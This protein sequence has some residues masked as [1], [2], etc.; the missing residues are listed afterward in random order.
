MTARVSIQ[1]DSIQHIQIATGKVSSVLRWLSSA[2]FVAL[3]FAGVLN[4]DAAQ[5]TL[6]VAAFAMVA[7]IFTSS[8]AFALNDDA[9]R[10]G[11]LGGASNPWS[12]QSITNHP[13][14]VVRLVLLSRPRR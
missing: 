7:I 12:N 5:L 9:I 13:H 3:G 4:P 14:G 6:V 1:P 8:G 10:M 2:S 11:V